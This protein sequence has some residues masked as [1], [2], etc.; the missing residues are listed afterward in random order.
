MRIFEGMSGGEIVDILGYGRPR[1]EWHY[2]GE[3]YVAY[4]AP[5]E[6]GEPDEGKAIIESRERRMGGL[7]K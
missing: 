5:V 2:E 1:V 3:D 7:L 6:E 4:I